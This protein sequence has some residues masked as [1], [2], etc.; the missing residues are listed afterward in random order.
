MKMLKSMLKLPLM[1]K[2]LIG[3]IIG[4]ILGLVVPQAK[5]VSIFGILFVGGL[6]GIAPLLVFTVVI[7]SLANASGKL[8]KR[9]VSVIFL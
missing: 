7:S 3:L 5:F 6:K 1:V 2:I 9:F 8:G 4:V